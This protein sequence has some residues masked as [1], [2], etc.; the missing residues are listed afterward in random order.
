MTLNSSKH[1][2]Y[3]RLSKE[4]KQA[5]QWIATN[6]TI[7]ENIAYDIW[8]HPELGLS[9]LKSSRILC[10]FLEKN[11]FIVQRG[12]PGMPTAFVASWGEGGPVIGF[13]AEYDALPNL[14]QKKMAITRAEITPGGPG[15][16]CGH[17]LLGSSCCMAAIAVKSA[18][19][20]FGMSGVIKVFGT[21]SEETLVGKVFMARDGVFDQTDV[22][23]S[24]HPEDCNCVD[25]KSFLALSSIKIRF[26][27][28]SSH[29]GSAPESGRS[30]LDAVELMSAG[31]NRMRSHL[32]QEARI[33]HVITHGG[34]VP[35]NIPPDAEIWYYVRA[36]RRFQVER[37]CS[38]LE[39]IANGAAL[40]TQTQMEYKLLTATWEVL[41]NKVL[42]EVGDLNATAIGPPEFSEKDQDF[43]RS[44]LK[45]LGLSKTGPA[46][47]NGV[48]H[49]TLE[50]DFPDLPVFKASTD[51]GN[52]S[53]MIPTLT[54]SVATKAKGTPQH[55]W[56]MVSQAFSPPAIKGGV[57]ASKWMAASALDCILY[58]DIVMQARKELERHLT[59]MPFYH[60]I[61]DDLPIPTPVDL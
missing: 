42:A 30:A 46:F 51:I 9:E 36:P 17:N 25:Y 3:G 41:P 45:T 4:K 34:D 27:G 32:P 53:W 56:Q 13:L 16:G 20:Q 59:K 14:S 52:V 18:L 21:P 5:L 54:F 31:T 37:I 60:P 39:D 33:M 2:R 7:Y 19:A 15:H 43:G 58:P 1:A 55:S 44:I 38:W 26:K 22:M 12:L 10:E 57:T 48:K 6:R 24:W 40:M 11:G 29:G 35:N 47:E 8:L 28:S 50:K 49:P 61:P 23:I